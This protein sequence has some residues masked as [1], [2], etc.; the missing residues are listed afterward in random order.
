MIW[1][2]TDDGVR[3]EGTTKVSEEE[4]LWQ[5]QPAKPWKAGKYQLGI[6]KAL[7]DLAGNSVAAPF[8]IDVFKPIQRESKAETALLTF[9]VR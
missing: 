5:F 9:E 3:I 6:N 1:V 7:E 4:M 2:T 8:E